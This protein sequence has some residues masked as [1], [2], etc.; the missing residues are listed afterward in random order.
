MNS[1]IYQLLGI[2]SFSAMASRVPCLHSQSLL[3]EDFSDQ[4][5]QGSRPSA[6]EEGLFAVRVLNRGV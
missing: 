6:L 3:V 1:S 5:Q 4:A 2:D